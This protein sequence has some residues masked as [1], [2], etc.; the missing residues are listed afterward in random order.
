VLGRRRRTIH[1]DLF[2]RGM[3]RMILFLEVIRKA[4]L[5]TSRIMKSLWSTCILEEI[6]SLLPVSSFHFIY[7]W[8]NFVA[9]QLGNETWFHAVFI[10]SVA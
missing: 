8:N 4:Y 5:K 1:T 3:D 6:M 9:R 7:S 2:L 10:I